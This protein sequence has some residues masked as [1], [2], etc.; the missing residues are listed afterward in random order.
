MTATA[1]IKTTAVEE[2]YTIQ[3]ISSVD[4]E[5]RAFFA[6]VL[7]NKDHVPIMIKDFRLRNVNL[8]DY[9]VVI[10]QGDGLEPDEKTQQYVYDNFIDTIR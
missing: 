8:E 2:Q 4:P 10:A 3:L 1:F 6:Y 5:G 7:M 9:G